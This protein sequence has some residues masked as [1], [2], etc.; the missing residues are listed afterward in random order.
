MQKSMIRS[1]LSGW[2]GGKYL[3]SRTIVPMIPEHQCYAEPFAG[4]AWVLFRKPPS[5]C[6]VLND[7]NR[8]VVNIYRVVQHHWEVFANTLQWSLSS[9]EEFD[10]LLDTPAESMTDIQR[11]ARY[12]YLHKLCFGGRVAGRMSFAISATSP[13]S[14]NPTSLRKEMEVA[15]RRL[16]RV[17]VEHLPYAD[18]IRIY[19]RAGTFFYIDPP[20][21]DCEHY[22][23]KGIFD[24][25]DFAK[26][27]D[28]LA[29]I[30]GMFL[31]SLNDTP[32][33]RDIFG[34]FHI[35]G[36]TVRYSCTTAAHPLAKEVLI[37]N[38]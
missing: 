14:F 3:L 11:A 12:Y 24:K 22:Y 10:R 28:Q 9:R 5:K 30:K 25:S 21:W 20:Y 23:G 27:A 13:I 29:G 15:H 4:A 35:E 19:D 18:L 31:L 7:I 16:A 32:E 6:E 36:A 33:V 17:T 37:R 2:M 8:D 34:G 38:Y 26:L 1:P